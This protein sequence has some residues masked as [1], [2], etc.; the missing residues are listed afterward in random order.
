MACARVS[1]VLLTL[2][3]PACLPSPPTLCSRMA[4]TPDDQLDLL[5]DGKL[6]PAAA[7]AGFP[8]DLHVR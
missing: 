3:I 1:K 6:L 5:F 8:S 2:A 4:L 7:A